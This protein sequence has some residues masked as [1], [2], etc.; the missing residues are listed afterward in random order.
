[1]LRFFVLAV[2][3]GPVAIHF[4]ADK[5]G[6]RM[7]RC[8][9]MRRGICVDFGKRMEGRKPER[10]KYRKGDNYSLKFCKSFLHLYWF[11]P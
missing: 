2:I 7:I 3:S 4:L 10:N 8:G 11:R 1:M 9:E 6:M 5:I